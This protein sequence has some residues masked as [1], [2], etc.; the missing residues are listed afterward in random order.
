M[1]KNL[2][3]ILLKHLVLLPYQEVRLELNNRISK[4]VVNLATEEYDSNLL[5]VCPTDQ[6][7]ESPEVSDLPS[8][9][10]VGKIKNIIELPNGNYRLVIVGIER[11]KINRYINYENRKD[12]LIAETEEVEEIRVSEIEEI[13]FQR[14]LVN[15]FYK[16]V[17]SS[18][19]ISNSIMGTI[20]GVS[21]LNRLTDLI[22]SSIPFN[23]ERKNNYMQELN[24]LIRAENLMH[25][26]SIEIEVTILD[27]KIEISLQDEFQNTQKEFIIKEKIKKLKTELGESNLKEEEVEK[28]KKALKDLNLNKK[29]FSNLT[30]EIKKY[31][32]TSESSPEAAVIRNYLDLVLNLPWKIYTQDEEDLNKIIKSLD[33]THYGLKEVKDRVIEY[34]AIKQ[35]NPDIKTPVLCLVG[36]PGVG[37]TTLTKTIAQSLNKEFF[38]LSVGGLNDATELIGHRR[39]YIGS[40]PGKIIKAISKCNSSNPLILIDEI[41][42]MV[43]DYKGDPASAFLDILDPE[44][45]KTFTDNYVEEPFDISKT[46]FIL[47]A[48]DL[49]SIPYPLRD[50]LEIIELSSY[51]EYEKVSIAK[52]HL[53]P[54]IFNDHK[55]TKS[56]IKFSTSIIIHIIDSYTK[57]AG[58]RDLERKLSKIVRKIV[59][60]NLKTKKEIKININKTNLKKYLGN[61]KYQNTNIKA[62]KIGIA[63]GLAYTPF[64]GTITVLE[65]C[66]VE[67]K[68]ELKLTGRLGP[69]M[70][71]S[72][73]VAISYIKANY[74]KFK[75]DKKIALNKN[76]HLNAIEGAINKEGPSAGIT[77]V[78]SILSLVLNKRVDKKVAMTGEITLNGEVLEIGGLKEK[79]IGGYREGVRIF[80][81]PISNQNDL[82]DIPE[83]ISKDI[84]IKL[85]KNYQEIYRDLFK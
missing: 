31:E 78:T 70:Q 55:V 69:V 85:V 43:K 37:K 51:T 3:V 52:N 80:Y 8:I 83:E 20:K 9:G 18:P 15:L 71:E 33:N 46:F 54:R 32:L 58:V 40:A 61:P 4:N 7:E 60:E 41:D 24:P 79:I 16:Y 53:L 45:N 30:S 34:I 64:G 44:Q 49:Y 27:E 75:I 73:Q 47:T 63:N 13:A 29:I 57:E 56:E 84:E 26:I 65:S 22:T 74:K 50:R 48:N 21:N 23:I 12:I 66:L 82:D 1:D 14:K 36:P 68:G 5:V 72:A 17:N 28:F 39:T 19:R 59:T 67:G 38:K 35:K 2:P 42:K 6:I 62:N 77:I 10:V 81:I 11:V 25:D 76:L